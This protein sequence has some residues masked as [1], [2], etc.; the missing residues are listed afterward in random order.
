[1]ASG[2]VSWA[3]HLVSAVKHPQDI[4]IC[5]HWDPDG[6]QVIRWI[7]IISGQCVY[8]T[9]GAVSWSFGI[10]RTSEPR[11][12]PRILIY[13]VVAVCTTSSNHHE[14]SK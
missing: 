5:T 3:G 14:L 11:L 9:L 10:P 8:G 13:L 4:E 6:V 12:I 1:M 7:E 2:D